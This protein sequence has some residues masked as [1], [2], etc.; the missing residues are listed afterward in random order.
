MLGSI[1]EK[2]EEI[3]NFDKLTLEYAKGIHKKY[4]VVVDI[5]TEKIHEEIEKN[6][7]SIFNE[8]QKKA[9]Y[10]CRKYI[11]LY[12]RLLSYA[13]K[14]KAIEK[15]KFIWYN[16]INENKEVL[17]FKIYSGKK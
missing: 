11:D 14:S 13:Q 2:L 10:L 7:N 17:D 4:T 12:E 1:I 9:Y 3:N 6:I 5:F 8:K 16:L 15:K